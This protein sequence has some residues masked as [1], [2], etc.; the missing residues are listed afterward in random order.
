MS[1]RF[2]LLNF[3]QPLPSPVLQPG[4][5]FDGRGPNM[6]DSVCCYMTVHPIQSGTDVVPFETSQHQS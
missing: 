4:P 3:T 2:E 5:L 1:G 6:A